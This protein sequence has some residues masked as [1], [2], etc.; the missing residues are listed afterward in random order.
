MRHLQPD[1]RIHGA[2]VGCAR[3]DGRWLLIRRSASVPSPLKVCFPGGGVD[4]GEAH[5]EAAVR[6]MREE[7][8]VEVELIR[9]VWH[10]ELDHANTTLWGWRAV[11]G[12]SKLVPDPAEVDEILWLTPS[13]VRQHPDALSSTAPFLEALL[14]SDRMTRLAEG[15]GLLQS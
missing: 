7:L 10:F 1:G 8:G 13:E 9:C 4:R 2:V 6:E 3:D 15:D 11:L 12:S 14:R 5:P